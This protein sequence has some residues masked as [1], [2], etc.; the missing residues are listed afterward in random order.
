MTAVPVNHIDAVRVV[1]LPADVDAA[2]AAEI[3]DQLAEQ[4]GVDVQ[5]LV[6]DLSPTRYLDSSGLDMLFKLEEQ[7]RVGRRGLCLVVPETSQLRRLLELVRLPESLT[8]VESVPAAVQACAG[9][10]SA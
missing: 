3:G 2:N 4:L 8:V 10:T 7:L 6:L 5:H 1:S 9:K